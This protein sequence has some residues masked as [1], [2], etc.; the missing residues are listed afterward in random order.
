MRLEGEKSQI[1]NASNPDF[2]LEA[3][4]NTAGIHAMLWHHQMCS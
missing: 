1:G 4:E 2:V 3:M